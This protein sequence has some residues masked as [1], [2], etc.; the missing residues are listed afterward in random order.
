MKLP[1][2]NRPLKDI[3]V[4]ASFLVVCVLLIFAAFWAYHQFLTTPPYVDPDRFPIRGIDVSAH[5][6]DID[7]EKVK[8]SGVEFVFIKATEGGDFKDK[9]FRINYEKANKAGLKKGIYHFFR[10]DKDGVEQALN[11][12]KA[13]GPRHPELGL[14]IDVEKFGNPDSI[15]S[16]LINERL[17]EMV[18]YLNLLGHRVTFYTNRAGYYDYLAESFPGYQLWICGFSQNPIYAEWTFWQFNHHGKVP[19]IKGD[20]DLNAFCG[21]REEWKR[22]LNGALWPYTTYN[23]Q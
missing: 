6:G 5:N 10:F 16:D 20:V 18:D 7:F 3:I 11:L 12:M 23:Q 15:P 19:G 4:A 22:Y 1:F 21:T 13:V 14:V 17:T 8:K 9:N 2:A